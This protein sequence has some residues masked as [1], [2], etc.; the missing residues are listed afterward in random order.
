AG[1]DLARRHPARLES[2]QPEIAERHLLTTSGQ[3]APASA[4]LL[5]ELHFLWHQHDAFLLSSSDL[6]RTAARAC[7]GLF[8]LQVQYLY[9]DALRVY[10]V[11]IVR[12]V[13]DAY[14]T[15]DELLQLVAELVNLSTL[16][17]DDD[18]RA[19]RVDV[20]A[21]LVRRALEVDL[22]DSGVREPLLEILAKLQIA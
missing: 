13:V 18:S 9:V 7:I 21:H 10:L 2:L 1:L 6:L 20:D 17:S 5:S 11:Y 4:L 19:R 14:L 15:N 8:A 16:A 3:T 12:L 22:R